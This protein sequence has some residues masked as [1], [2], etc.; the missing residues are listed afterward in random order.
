MR[1]WLSRFC[2][3]RVL[4]CLMFPCLL[5][6]L[7]ILL[8]FLSIPSQSVLPFFPSL[9]AACCSS[10]TCIRFLRPSFS[11]LSSFRFSLSL[12]LF[13]LFLFTNAQMVRFRSRHRGP[14]WPVRLPSGCIRGRCAVLPTSPLCLSALFLVLSMFC[15]ARVARLSCMPMRCGVPWVLLLYESTSNTIE[16]SSA[17]V[18]LRMPSFNP[19]YSAT[20]FET[21]PS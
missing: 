7:L 15:S 9:S 12:S 20:F 3:L 2:L 13:L 16:V 19:S 4:V 10:L 11:A 8:Y 6:L 5:A 14:Y 1:F 21:R 18:A 17:L